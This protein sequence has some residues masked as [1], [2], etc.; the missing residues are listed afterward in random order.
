MRCLFRPIPLLFG[1][2]SGL[3]RHRTILHTSLHLLFLLSPTFFDTI[4]SVVL[5]ARKCPPIMPSPL[6]QNSTETLKT[7]AAEARS[8]ARPSLLYVSIFPALRAAFANKLLPKMQN[9]L[10]NDLQFATTCT[11]RTISLHRQTQGLA[12]SL[13][14]AYCPRARMAEAERH[15]ALY[16]SAYVRSI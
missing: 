12:V 16:C 2:G 3:T 5:N 6:P 10:K 14:P 13:H 8:R 4:R 11:P 7:F 15:I 1:M 9:G